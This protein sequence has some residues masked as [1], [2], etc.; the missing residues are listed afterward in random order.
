MYLFLLFFPD[1]LNTIHA[2]FLAWMIKYFPGHILMSGLVWYCLALTFAG[3]I[4][5]AVGW[6]DSLHLTQQLW[7]C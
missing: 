7:S 2:S 1:N 5:L 3:T 6:Y 4:G